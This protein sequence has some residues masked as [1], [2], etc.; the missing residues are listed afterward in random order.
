MSNLTQFTSSTP[1]GTIIQS[2]ANISDPNW[3]RCDGS[4]ITR[5][6]YPALSAAMPGV[7]TFTPTIRAATPYFFQQ[8]QSLISNG[9][10]MICLTTLTGNNGIM[11]STNGGVTWA[12]VTSGI[13]AGYSFSGTALCGSNFVAGVMTATSQPAYA[14]AAAPTTWS[15]A[16]GITLS[17]SG[18]GTI[19]G[20]AAG[21]A[22]TCW[23]GAGYVSTNSGVSYTATTGLV[24]ASL[25]VNPILIWTGNRFIAFTAGT[26]NGVGFQYSATG[27]SASWTTVVSAPWGV[28]AITGACSDGANNVLVVVGSSSVAYTSADG[29]ATWRQ[30]IL[31]YAALGGC[32]YANG[33][34]FI[35]MY[36][37]LGTSMFA[38]GS[39]AVSTDLATWFL[40]PNLA[41]PT[42]SG[43]SN[44]QT[45]IAYAGGNYCALNAASAGNLPV[46]S[47]ENTAQMYLPASRRSYVGSATQVASIANYQE[48]IKAA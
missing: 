8:A 6:S 15:I 1:V 19:A 9:T 42:F 33:R 26:T 3:L 12:A 7:G 32:N 5:A 44:T 31:P 40:I 25:S 21:T 38:D 47:T 41:Y 43:N 28:N 14:S 2:P 24:T 45:A 16:S 23:N 27:A 11:V 10:N 34:F 29:G 39:V 13:T 48:W 35:P 20:N 37:L 22:V 17:G 46:T 4:I 36:V 18:A 30:T